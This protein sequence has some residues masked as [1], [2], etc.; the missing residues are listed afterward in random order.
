MSDTTTE[1]PALDAWTAALEHSHRRLA[2][3]VAPLSA[4]QVAG[5]SYDRDWSIAEVLSHIGS[6]AE[7]FQLFLRAGL[8][9]EDPPGPEAFAPIWDRWNAKTPVDQAADAVVTDRAF[10]DRLADVD[11]EARDAFG[12]DLFGERRGFGELL[13]LR[14]GEHA[15]HTWDVV[16][17]D[18]PHATIAPDAV[19]LLIDVVH[20]LVGMVGRPSEEAVRVHVTTTSPARRLLIEADA[21]GARLTPS[22][23]VPARSG[24]ATLAL[25]AE[26]LLRLVYGRLDE[27][28]TPALEGDPAVLDDLRRVF[29]GF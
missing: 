19:E 10:L 9:G 13:R 5:P 23:G 25:P 16:V 21:D 1:Q 18:D 7:I 3:A 20:Q 14:L 11:G 8:L 28:H 6:G 24:D 4:D 17:M 22:D 27:G 15:V 29:P 2:D 26:A 12:L